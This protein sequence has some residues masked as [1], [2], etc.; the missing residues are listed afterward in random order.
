M[1]ER[2]TM[3]VTT[4]RESERERQKENLQTKL[5]VTHA[6]APNQQTPVLA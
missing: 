5:A 2:E 6:I 4:E 1:K 3:C